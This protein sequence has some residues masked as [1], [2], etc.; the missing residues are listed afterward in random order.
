MVSLLR[1][2]EMGSSPSGSFTTDE[3]N[4]SFLPFQVAKMRPFPS[5]L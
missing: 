2:K 1:Q 4:D 3:E 5:P